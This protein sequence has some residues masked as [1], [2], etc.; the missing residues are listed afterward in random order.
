MVSRIKI[1]DSQAETLL[2][3]VLA[4]QAARTLGQQ[5]LVAL[6][7]DLA[8]RLAVGLK[9]TRAHVSNAHCACRHVLCAEALVEVLEA[10]AADGRGRKGDTGGAI[11][12]EYSAL[13]PAKLLTLPKR[14][15]A[16]RRRI[17]AAYP[18][19]DLDLVRRAMVRNDLAPDSVAEVLEDPVNYRAFLR[20]LPPRRST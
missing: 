19:V 16:E 15:A 17:K 20:S 3:N 18:E 14:P 1:N 2:G 8:R 5:R 9:Q 12:D 11:V 13:V 6:F 7:P 4:G 10:R